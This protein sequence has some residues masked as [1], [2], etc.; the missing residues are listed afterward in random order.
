YQTQ[1]DAYERIYQRL[2]LEYVIVSAHAG[3]MGGSRSEEFLLPTDAGED[4]FVLSE[5]G[6]A[7]TVEALRADDAP[8]RPVHG[9]P[10]APAP[11]TRS[12]E[13]LPGATVRDTPGTTTIDTLVEVSNASH[14]R[15]DGRRWTAADTLKNVVLAL[16]A[17]SGERELVVVGLPGDR[18]VDL[19]RA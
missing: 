17:P 11:A 14:P 15:A 6:Y 8:A 13:G 9:L 2:G 7:A 3:A 18:E 10:A 1:R 19:G 5:A 16:V 4:S 12:A